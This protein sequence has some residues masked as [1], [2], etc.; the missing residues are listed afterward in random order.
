MYPAPRALYRFREIR[1]D[2]RG[3]Q[4]PSSGAGVLEPLGHV[5]RRVRELPDAPPGEEPLVPV[6]VGGKGTWV[7]H[8]HLEEGDA[9]WARH[10]RSER[11]ALVEREMGAGGA[12]DVAA[13]HLARHDEHDVIA[14]VAVRLH[15]H[16]RVP[17]G[18]EGEEAGREIEPLLAHRR[19]PVAVLLT[20]HL[21]P[22]EVVQ[23]SNPRAT[24]HESPPI[25]ASSG[26]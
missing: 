20:A 15:D 8:H 7:A 14:V 11:V 10:E 25:W 18:V 16:P 21:L 1:A 13:C 26:G 4:A 6:E 23:M 12:A 5:D 19:R 2:L 9:V 24:G 22:R 3:S 17:L